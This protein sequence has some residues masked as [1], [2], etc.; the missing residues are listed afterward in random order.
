MVC[1][2]RA[3]SP[4]CGVWSGG[5]AKRKE[6]AAVQTKITLPHGVCC[7]ELCLKSSGIIA[8]GASQ[9]LLRPESEF[10]LNL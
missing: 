1:P 8:E 3:F 6:E 9:H 7:A 5:E 2:P 4:L 10:F